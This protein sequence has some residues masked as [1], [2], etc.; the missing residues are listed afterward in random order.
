MG[1]TGKKY[2]KYNAEFKL[3]VIVDMREHHIGLLETVMKYW[4]VPYKQAH[5]YAGNLHRWERIFI[6]EG[7]EGLMKERRGKS[8]FGAR[9]GR[10]LKLGK[11]V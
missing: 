7:A 11:K 5:C 8:A 4:N 10:Q 3:C 2:K 6:E 9:I 1:K